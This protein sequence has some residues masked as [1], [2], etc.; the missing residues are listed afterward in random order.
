[1][2]NYIIIR[3]DDDGTSVSWLQEEE[4][5]DVKKLMEDHGIKNFLTEWSAYKTPD[6]W[7][8]GYAMLLEVKIKKVVP[9]EIV[10]SYKIE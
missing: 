2:K 5:Q 7:E 4:L 9:I 10:N 3:R 6:Y 8:E 1:M